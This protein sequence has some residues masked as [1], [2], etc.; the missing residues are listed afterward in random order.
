MAGCPVRFAKGVKGVIA[1]LSANIAQIA[2]WASSKESSDMWVKRSKVASEA[3]GRVNLGAT[4]P[5]WASTR[6]HISREKTPFAHWLDPKG[7]RNEH[8]R[9]QTAA[10]QSA[11]KRE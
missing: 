4:G 8:S 3:Q 7:V 6:D 10:L 11:T 1:R 9:P 5:W 2:S